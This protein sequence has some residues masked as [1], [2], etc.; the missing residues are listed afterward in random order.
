M[1]IVE[2]LKIIMKKLYRFIKFLIVDVVWVSVRF[3]LEIPQAIYKAFK[4]KEN[5]NKK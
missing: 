2:I 1:K 5:E 4:E 3:Y